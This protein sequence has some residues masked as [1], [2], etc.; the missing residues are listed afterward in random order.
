M[1]HLY[2]AQFWRDRADKALIIADTLVT[3]EAR[4]TLLDI[5]RAYQRLVAMSERRAATNRMAETGDPG[6]RR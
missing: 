1:P 3:P 2:D 4:E 5:A 6:G